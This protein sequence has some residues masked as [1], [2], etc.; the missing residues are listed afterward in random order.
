M[1]IKKVK[2]HTLKKV[3][4]LPDSAIRESQLKRFR[5]MVFTHG[6]DI[7]QL[8][9]STG[10]CVVTDEEWEECKAWHKRLTDKDWSAFY[11]IPKVVRKHLETNVNIQKL[12]VGV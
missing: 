7:V 2:R 8:H 6:L 4:S 10:L 3:L 12:L 9:R 5:D 11:D 1:E